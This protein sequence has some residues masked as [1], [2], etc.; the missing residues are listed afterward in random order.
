MRNF[1][2]GQHRFWTTPQL[3]SGQVNNMLG[4]EDGYDE[5]RREHPFLSVDDVLRTATL[6]I[7]N[8]GDG[9][10]INR[11][12]RL[13][14]QHAES[15]ESEHVDVADAVNDAS[16]SAFA[17]NQI[18]PPDFSFSLTDQAWE[19]FRLENMELFD[20]AIANIP[21][22][23]HASDNRSDL[24]ARNSAFP[25]QQSVGHIDF[26]VASAVPS[27]AHFKVPPRQDRQ[28]RVSGQRLQ[29]QGSAC[30][31]VTDDIDNASASAFAHNYIP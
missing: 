2:E 7:P 31:D 3:A 19:S 12:S 17:H 26:S 11:Q 22:A 18:P 10:V 23:I 1:E 27:D 8:N 16:A 14:D 13:S 29:P 21:T 4:Y 24:D 15:Q 9:L 28:P 30:L 6:H 5:F 20:D 25:T